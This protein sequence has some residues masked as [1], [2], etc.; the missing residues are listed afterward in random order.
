MRNSLHKTDVRHECV[1]ILREIEEKEVFARELITAKCSQ[2]DLS[3]QDKGLLTELVNSVIRHC[4]PLAPSF[5]WLYSKNGELEE[6]IAAFEKAIELSP[7]SSDAH[8][9]LGNRYVQ[10][11]EIKIAL[12]EY[13]KAWEILFKKAQDEI[14]Q[15]L[16]YF[17]EG[18]VEQAI[19]CFNEVLKI[20]P[21]YEEAYVFLADAYEKKG[22]YSAGM[23]L[24]LEGERLKHRGRN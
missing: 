4:L 8:R 1:R 2:G 7:D 10:K 12:T 16:S 20:N 11:G 6:A 15:G 5:P 24:R 13:H 22:L 14:R 23:A 3:R 9:Y 17:Q 21:E 18:N 19:D